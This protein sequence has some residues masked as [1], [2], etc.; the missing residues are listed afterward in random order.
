MSDPFIGEIRS[1]GGTTVPTGWLPCN[2]QIISVAPPYVALFS[3][4]GLTYGGGSD[5]KTFALP[6]LQAR[7]P[8]GAGQGPGLTPHIVGEHG[9]N[10]RVNLVPYTMASHSHTANAD[11]SSGGATSPQNAVWGTQGR[12]TLPAYYP[13]PPNVAMN[14]ESIGLTGGDQP[15]NNLPPYLALNFCIAYEGEF[16]TRS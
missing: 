9:G 1:F 12:G 2:G 13:G 14:P 16:P 6:D 8:I 7:V 10:A 15:H 3:V 5:S 4:I 11:G